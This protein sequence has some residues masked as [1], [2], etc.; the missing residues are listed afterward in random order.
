MFDHHSQ[1]LSTHHAPLETGSKKTLRLI[2]DLFCYK[3]LIFAL[4][5]SHS[6][7]TE[8]PWA[9][10]SVTAPRDAVAVAGSQIDTNGLACDPVAYRGQNTLL[11]C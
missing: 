11:A 2:R 3:F 5:L 10:T 6:T 1:A 8:A 7:S 9:G 4:C